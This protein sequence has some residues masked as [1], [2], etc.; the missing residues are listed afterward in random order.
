MKKTI[1][2]LIVFLLTLNAYSGGVPSKVIIM[3]GK[4]RSLTD[5]VNVPVFWEN[6]VSDIYADNVLLRITN[7]DGKMVL[8]RPVNL[9]QFGCIVFDKEPSQGIYQIELVYPKT[10]IQG[11][12]ML[13]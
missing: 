10:T 1:S 2:I 6:D 13:E 7:A 9:E 3:K 12:F 8:E 5:V 11:T 4:T